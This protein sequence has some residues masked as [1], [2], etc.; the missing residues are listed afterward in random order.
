MN[1]S[2]HCVNAVYKELAKH[3]LKFVCNIHLVMLLYCS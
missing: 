2:A 3:L 1:D